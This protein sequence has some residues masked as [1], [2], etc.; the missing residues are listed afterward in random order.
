VSLPITESSSEAS[1]T[2]FSRSAASS[3]GRFF[4]N[5][6]ADTALPSPSIW[7]NFVVLSVAYFMAD[8]SPLAEV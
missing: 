6:V 3:K 8:L 7:G 5:K 1:R 2:S 4:F